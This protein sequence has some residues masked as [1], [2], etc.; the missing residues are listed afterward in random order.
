MILAFPVLAENLLHMFVGVW[1]T[2][3][4]NH[5]PVEADQSPAGSAVGSIAYFL[6]FFGLLVS[7]IGAGTTAIIARAKGARHK[8]MANSVTGQSISS[9]ILVGIIIGTLLYFLSPMLISLIRL[10]GAAPRFALP[11]LQMLSMTLPF[12]MVMNVAAS[13]QRGYGDTLTAGVVMVI[14]DIIN[15]VFSYGLTFGKFGLPL[16]GFNGIALGTIVAYVAGGIIQFA[17]LMYGRNGLK[18]H[19]HRMRPHW[20]TLKRLI[21]IGIPAAVEGLLMW[22]SNIGVIRVV[23][24]MDATNVMGN[25]HMIAIRIESFSFMTGMAIAAAAATMVGQSLGMKDPQRA[26][27]SALAAYAIGGGA[28]TFFGVLFIAFGKHF[29][30]L[31]SN[32]SQIVEL[33]AKCLFRTGFIQ[34][35]FAAYIIFSSVLRGAG[36]TFVVMILSL[37]SVICVRFIG[38]MIVAKYHG[39]LPTLWIVLCAELF[40]RG[41]LA[42]GRFLQGGWKKVKV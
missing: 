16:L 20:T 30:M 40:F 13:C 29:A 3:L 39:S 6:W 25:A 31:I 36:D 35:G 17:V 26:Q 4:A 21:R 2:Y 34:C 32:D 38:A 22:L 7:S 12:T 11:Y 37:C 14:V 41:C 27:K 33:V 28:M 9:A 18:L 5:L 23:N 15:A 42:A 1:D 8:S 24:S 19:L 10:E